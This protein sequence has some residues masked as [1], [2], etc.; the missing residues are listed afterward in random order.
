MKNPDRAAGTLAIVLH[1]KGTTIFQKIKLFA[2]FFAPSV[3]GGY[4]SGLNRRVTDS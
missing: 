4:S 2:L 3:I 1:N